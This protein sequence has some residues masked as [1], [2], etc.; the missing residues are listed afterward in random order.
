VTLSALRIAELLGRAAPTPDQI[1]IIESPLSPLLV[2]RR[3]PPASSPA[4]TELVGV[5]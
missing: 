4:E 1:E 2:V 5:D 3:R